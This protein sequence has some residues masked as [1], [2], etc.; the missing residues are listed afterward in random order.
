V[1]RG[2]GHRG[3]DCSCGGVEVAGAP[4]SASRTAAALQGRAAAG[5]PTLLVVG[6]RADEA[7]P[8]AFMAI[9]MLEEIQAQ[10]IF[11]SAHGETSDDYACLSLLR[12][13][14]SHSLGSRTD[15][16]YITGIYYVRRA[17]TVSGC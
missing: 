4:A 12:D 6:A 8:C 2:W 3:H 15:V 1:H 9:Y 13:R 11:N 16:D 10:V 7:L 5:H 17:S 14:P